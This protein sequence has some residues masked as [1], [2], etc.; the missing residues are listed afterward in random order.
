MYAWR[1]RENELKKC[2][3]NI[4]AIGKM[5]SI[6]SISYGGPFRYEI[7]HKTVDGIIGSSVRNMMMILQT[8]TFPFAWCTQMNNIQRQQNAR[9]HPPSPI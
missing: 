4:N 5:Y 8:N 2:Y 9:S 1:E 3:R 7:L 6:R